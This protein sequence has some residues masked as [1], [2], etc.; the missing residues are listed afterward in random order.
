MNIKLEYAHSCDYCPRVE[1]QEFKVI[2]IDSY[3]PKAKPIR[4][5]MCFLCF[6]ALKKNVRQQRGY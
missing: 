4:L 5:R 3:E 1:R 6:K 2:R